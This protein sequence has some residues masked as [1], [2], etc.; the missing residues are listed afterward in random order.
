VRDSDGTAIFTIALPPLT[1]G[2]LKTWNF[3][4]KIGKPVMH[5]S[6]RGQALAP[7]QIPSP[8]TRLRVF[9]EKYRVAVLNV[10]GPRASD[11]PGVYGFVR[12]VLDALLV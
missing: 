9:V 5:I 4:Q 12:D 10:A 6:R 11:E 1:K 3:A 7:Y 2:S 8:A